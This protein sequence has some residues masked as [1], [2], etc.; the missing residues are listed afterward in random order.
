MNIVEL[1]L[2]CKKRSREV[3]ETAK[4]RL[5]NHPFVDTPINQNIIND[6]IECDIK[7]SLGAK[8][9]KDY[10]SKYSVNKNDIKIIDER[11]KIYES[12]V[13][14]TFKVFANKNIE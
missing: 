8:I 9:L 7:E 2:I 3:F 13:I 14:K 10:L 11:I 12:I 1:D 5:I 4:Y 6:C